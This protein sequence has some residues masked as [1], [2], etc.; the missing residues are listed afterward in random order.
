MNI[1]AF[2]NMSLFAD[3]EI[4]EIEKIIQSCVP[5]KYKKGSCIAREGEACNAFG[6]VASGE[7]IILKENARGESQIL[8]KLSSGKTFVEMLVYSSVRKWPATVW[9]AEDSIVYFM[10]LQK[11]FR[12]QSEFPDSYAKVLRNFIREISDKALGLNKKLE[13]LSLKKMRAR[14]ANYIIEQAK[15]QGK[16]QNDY[17]EIPLN[18]NELADFLA[19]SRPSMSRELTKMKEDKLIDFHKNQFRILNFEQLRLA[20][21]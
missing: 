9:A 11:M 19:V 6:I 4:S 10:D 7:I 3:I 1:E 21:E 8:A 12:I 13:Y 16:Q 2:V 18:R 5:K 17:F 20:I 14:L 15:K